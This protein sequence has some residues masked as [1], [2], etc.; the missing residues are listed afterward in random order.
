MIQFPKI[1]VISHRCPC[2]LDIKCMT[3]RRKDEAKNTTMTH[4]KNMKRYYMLPHFT[5]CGDCC[6]FTNGNL[7]VPPTT[8]GFMLLED[9]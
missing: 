5:P 3:M 7:S 2:V 9:M 6:E 8:A 1:I 4:T